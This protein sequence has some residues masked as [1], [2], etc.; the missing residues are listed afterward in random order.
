VYIDGPREAAFEL[1]TGKDGIAK[2]D[3]TPTVSFRLWST[4]NYDCPVNKS[5]PLP[6][7]SASEV[8]R[9]GLVT[10][11]TCGKI[12]LGL[13]PGEVTYS[14]RPEYWWEKIRDKFE[15]D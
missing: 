8:L 11:N 7:Y 12:K 1:P 14:V 13:R 9:S 3:I 4:Y 5:F 2:L 15:N 10:A 6:L